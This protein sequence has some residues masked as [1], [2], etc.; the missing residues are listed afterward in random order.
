M[1]K[2]TRAST[3][4]AGPMQERGVWLRLSEL[5]MVFRDAHRNLVQYLELDTPTCNFGPIFLVSASG[6]GRRKS[7]M[8]VILKL[9]QGS[10]LHETP[11]ERGSEY[12]CLQ[13][14]SPNG[15]KLLAFELS[16]Q[17]CHI[18]DALSPGGSSAACQLSK[19]TSITQAVR[20][21]KYNQ[22]TPCHM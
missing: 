17:L 8:S 9:D 21:L 12:R 10:Y 4:G 5:G 11:W 3:D 13:A 6:K 22:A 2:S 1:A 7:E 14:R 16:G 18:F 19:S 15:R 20:C